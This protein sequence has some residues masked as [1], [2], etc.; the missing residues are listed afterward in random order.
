MERYRTPG[1]WLAARKQRRVKTVAAGRPARRPVQA[2][3]EVS[4]EKRS[5]PRA[6]AA[7]G[8]TTDG[9]WLAAMLRI[10]PDVGLDA[11]RKLWREAE[12]K[13]RQGELAE[14]DSM[15][16]LDLLKARMAALGN[17]LPD[18]RD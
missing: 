16:V 3:V 4:R 5:K 2:A 15:K 13:R 10:V 1:A 12:E 14:A 7:Q 6:A 11:C 8:V 9:E 17:P 18:L